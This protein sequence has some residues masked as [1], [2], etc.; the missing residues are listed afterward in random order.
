M[1]LILTILFILVLG[2]AVFVY[3]QNRQQNAQARQCAKEGQRFNEK[4]AQLS[5]PSH[6]LLTR[7]W[8]ISRK[9]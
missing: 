5:D 1:F 3:W 6:F 7:N 4:L 8:W 2:G 9:R